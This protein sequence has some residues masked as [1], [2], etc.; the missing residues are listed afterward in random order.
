MQLELAVVLHCSDTTCHVRCLD[1]GHSLDTYHSAQMREHGI[2]S[3][4]GQL[5]AVDVAVSP[6]LIVYRWTQIR[7]EPAQEG[8]RLIAEGQPVDPAQLRADEFPQIEAMYARMDATLDVDPKQLV[9]DGYDQ[10]AERYLQWTTQ[11]SNGTRERYVS[12]LLDELSQGA[13]VLELGCGAGVPATQRLALRFQVTGVDISARQLELACQNAPQ[14][15]FIQADMTALEFSPESYDGIL[16]LFAIFHV[17]RNEQPQLFTQIATWL[18]PGGLLVA[19]MGTQSSVGGV[20]D[21]WLGAP[22]YWSTYD[23]ETNVRLVREAGLEIVRTEIETVEEFGET[24][25]FLWIIARKPNPQPHPTD[26][27]PAC[28]RLP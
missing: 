23:S 8:Y 18:R 21:N 3:R 28:S 14:A 17:P 12:W 26:R 20:E 9:R 13:S 10:I 19:T 11:D 5:V 6:P 16:S 24:V 15:S 7:A 27:G 2:L 4:P 25:S 22:M 1:R